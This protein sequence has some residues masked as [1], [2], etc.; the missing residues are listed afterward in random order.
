MVVMGM[1]DKDRLQ[2]IHMAE[3]Q[4]TI[5]YGTI[6]RLTPADIFKQ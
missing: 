5:H 4:L 3:R 1:R 6:R 2:P